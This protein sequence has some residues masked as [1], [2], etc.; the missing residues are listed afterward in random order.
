M[1][2]LNHVVLAGKV[3]GLDPRNSEVNKAFRFSVTTH[4]MYIEEGEKKLDPEVH[5]VK[6]LNA[7]TIAKHIRLGKNIVLTGRVKYA[8]DYPYILA[9]QIHLAGGSD[10]D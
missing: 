9:S 5:Q 2:S 10:A 6:L 4:Q 8:K 7:K 1:E 3:T